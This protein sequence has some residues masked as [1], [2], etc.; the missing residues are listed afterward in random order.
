MT[1]LA[2]LSSAMLRDGRRLS[3]PRTHVLYACDA[4]VVLEPT[5]GESAPE[6]FPWDEVTTLTVAEKGGELAA[7]VAAA[8]SEGGSFTAPDV[9]RRPGRKP[10]VTS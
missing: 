6:I 4:G 5:D 3:P 8:L 1:P 9:R 2:L 7:Q 10:R